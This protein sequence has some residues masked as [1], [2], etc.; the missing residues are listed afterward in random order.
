[1]VRADDPTCSPFVTFTG[2][3]NGVHNV[4]TFTMPAGWHCVEG[5]DSPPG[6]RVQVTMVSNPAATM[7]EGIPQEGDSS[8]TLSFSL[9]PAASSV[10]E[11]AKIKGKKFTVTSRVPK[12]VKQ[13]DPST[14]DQQA[15]P[16]H[17]V[18]AIDVVVVD[19][20]P[21]QVSR[22]TNGPDVKALKD[23]GK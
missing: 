7:E 2:P 9:T 13:D 20:W 5:T 6:N 1:A 17:Y 14:W 16:V 8:I 18:K 3:A 15:E 22:I 10:P 23:E 4:W 19:G 12:P 11:I 21:V